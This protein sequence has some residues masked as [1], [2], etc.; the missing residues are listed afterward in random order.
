[1]P[2]ERLTRYDLGIIQKMHDE[3]HYT[4]ADRKDLAEQLEKIGLP[5]NVSRFDLA[6]KIKQI[7]GEI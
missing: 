3:Q 1:M 6:Q 7:E 2:D 4:C 5:S